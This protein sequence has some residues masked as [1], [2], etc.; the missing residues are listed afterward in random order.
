MP[1]HLH[2]DFHLEEGDMVEVTIDRQ[3]NVML[4]FHPSGMCSG[5]LYVI[6]S[7]VKAVS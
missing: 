6:S 1:A 2:T 3:A 5:A 7:L 4:L